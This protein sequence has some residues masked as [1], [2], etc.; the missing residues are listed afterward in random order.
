MPIQCSASAMLL[1]I[2]IRF[3]VWLQTQHVCSAATA[4]I[5]TTAASLTLQRHT[6]PEPSSNLGPDAAQIVDYRV[7][8]TT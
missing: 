3:L 7:P 4:L 6:H 1:T 8:G 5:N 2:A